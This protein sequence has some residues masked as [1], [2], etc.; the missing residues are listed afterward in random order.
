MSSLSSK[1]KSQNYLELR[2]ICHNAYNNAFKTE[3]IEALMNFMLTVIM[4]IKS[5]NDDELISFG[6]DEGYDKTS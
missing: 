6:F 2:E 4:N 3:T 1:Q 5:R